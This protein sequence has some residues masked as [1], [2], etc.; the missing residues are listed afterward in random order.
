MTDQGPTTDAARTVDVVVIDLAIRLAL[1]GLL[2]YWSLV[3]IGPFVTIVLWGIV[4][5]VA[6]YPTFSWLRR[7]LWNSGAVAAVIITVLFLL[8]VI[9]PVSLL[10]A[11]LVENVQT[12]ADEIAAGT[13]GVPPPDERV[14]D[15]PLVGDHLY[16]FWSLASSNLQ[17]AVERI[18]PELKGLGTVLLSAAAGTGLG[19]V[20]FVASV[21]IAGCLLV[22]G[23]R[24]STGLSSIAVR[25]AASRGQPFVLLAAA[26]IRNVARGVIGVSLLQSLLIG[27]GLLAAGVPGAGLITVGCL[28]LGIIQI[29]PGILVIASIVWAWFELSTVSALVFTVYMVPVLLMDNV[30]RPIVMSRGLATPML[31]IFV[32]VIGG[33][34]AHGLIGLFIGPIV[35]AVAYELAI[36][37]VRGEDRAQGLTDSDKPAAVDGPQPQSQ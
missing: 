12:F 36:Y 3:L 32:G 27:M 20:K 17:G 26:T 15:L 10:A 11:A 23:M 21:I 37:W 8:V 1:I 2:L 16:G 18:A 4:L 31:V 9:G 5:A 24:L 25:V 13:L 7:V 22:P 14:K 19:I 33:T 29:G 35:L 30:L 6:L 34:L 28:F